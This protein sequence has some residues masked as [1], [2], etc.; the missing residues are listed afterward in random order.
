MRT[1]S[2]KITSAERTKEVA[3]LML[4]GVSRQV[5]NNHCVTKYGLAVN[6]VNHLV[7]DAYAFIRDN[8]EVDKTAIVSTH[9]KL[10]YDLYI[11]SLQNNDRKSALKSLEQIERLLKLHS[12]EV[13]IQNNNVTI[14]L[15]DL[16]ISEL[17]N[18]LK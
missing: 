16:D 5:I 3:E 4:T 15:K 1:I 6:S 14:S 7:F 13:A 18:L 17:K 9:I 8:Y 10:Y 2:T 11:N 12:P